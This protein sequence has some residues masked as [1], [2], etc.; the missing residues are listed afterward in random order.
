MSHLRPFIS[1]L[2]APPFNKAG[3]TLRGTTM[4]PCIKIDVKG[5]EPN[6]AAEVW[7]VAPQYAILIACLTAFSVADAKQRGDEFVALL[8][9]A[10]KPVIQSQ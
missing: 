8:R 7:L 4:K 1:I 5:N 2:Y 10:V 9:A 6:C 3:R